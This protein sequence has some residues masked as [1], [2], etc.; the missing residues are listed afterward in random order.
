MAHRVSISYGDRS[1]SA[2]FGDYGDGM[3]HPELATFVSNIIFKEEG[4]RYW[5]PPMGQTGADFPK[6]YGYMSVEVDGHFIRYTTPFKGAAD[7]IAF[8]SRFWKEWSQI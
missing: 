6:G 3:D 8:A 7:A 1:K 5:T 4:I 2:L